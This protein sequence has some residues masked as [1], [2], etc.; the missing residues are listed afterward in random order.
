MLKNNDQVR[1]Q[2]CTCHN[3]SAAMICTNLWHYRIIRI[4]IQRTMI[5]IDLSCE[6]M[7][8]F[9]E[10]FPGTTGLILGLH[11]ANERRCYK[12]TPSLIG[13]PQTY[14]ESC[15]RLRWQ[16]ISLF[17]PS[18]WETSLQSNTISHW[19]AANLESALYQVKVAVYILDKLTQSDPD[20]SIYTRDNIWLT[21]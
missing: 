16:S 8:P 7:N 12:V 17:A 11:P 1:S 19:L 10:W 13:W 3:S 4:I 18:Q 6:L 20:A 21:Y 5:Y 2:F 15:A 9:I 14:S